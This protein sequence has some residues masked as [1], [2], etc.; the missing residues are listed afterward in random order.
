MTTVDPCRWRALVAA[1]VRMAVDDASNSRPKY[2]YAPDARAK[3]A[4]EARAWLL[5]EEA[6][7]M[8]EVL[9]LNVADVRAQ[10]AALP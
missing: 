1:V 8:Y 10:I 7:R 4:T 9:D 2:V 5:S 3:L 6:A